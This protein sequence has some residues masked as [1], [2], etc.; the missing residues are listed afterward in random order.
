VGAFLLPFLSAKAAHASAA[1]LEKRKR[2]N[3]QH[4]YNA[5]YW[6]Y[7]TI[8]IVA[9]KFFADRVGQ[10]TTYRSLAGMF[11]VCSMTLQK[12]APSKN[13]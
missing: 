8:A 13:S 6:A 9:V 3:Y 1:C 4:W 5:F 11:A 12:D 10:P 2:I 7:G